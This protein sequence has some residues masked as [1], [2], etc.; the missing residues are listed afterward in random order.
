MRKTIARWWQRLRA[1]GMVLHERQQGQ[2]LI[3]IVFAFIGILAFIGLGVDLANVYTERVKVARAADAAALAAAAELPL[4]DAAKE[5]A[6]AYLQENGYDHT[7]T[8][9]VR[10]LVDGVQVSGPPEADAMTTIW[11]DTAYARKPPSYLEDTPDRIKVRVKREVFMMFMQFVGFTHFPVE[12]TAEAENITS[13]DTVIVYDKSGS[14]EFDTLCYGCWEPVAGQMYPGGDIYPLHWSEITTMTADHCAGWNTETQTYDCGN[15]TSY[16]STYDH[17]NCNYRHHTQTSRYWI[18]I[19]AEE[20]SRLSVDYHRYAYTPGKTYWVVQHNG[21][22]ALYGRP[23][24]VHGAYL[25]HHPYYVFDEGDREVDLG[26]SCVQSAVEDGVC[27]YG[28]PGG[29]F[30]APRADYDFYAPGSGTHTYY[31][32]IRGQGGQT[33]DDDHIFWGVDKPDP[34]GSV[35]VADWFSRDTGINYDGAD[36]GEWE[37]RKLGQASLSQGTHTLNLWAGGAGFDVDRIVISTYDS[38]STPPWDIQDIP[39]NNGRTD[40]ACAPC[41]PRFAGRPGGQTPPA[42]PYRPDCAIDLRSDDIYDDEQPIRAALEAA[43]NFVA[44]LNPRF[45]QI[46]YVRYSGSVEIANEL[47]CLRH[48]GPE[49]VEGNPACNPDWSDPGGEPPRDPDCGCFA[50]VITDTVLYELDVTRAGGSTNIAGGIEQG[51]DVLSTGGSHYGRPGAA[52]VMVL[53]TDGEA[54]VRPNNYCD[55]EDLW[56]EG[57]GAKDCVVYYAQEARDNAIVIYTI[58]LGWSADREL[59]GYVADLTGGEHFFAPSPDK[60][61]PI[62][63]DLFERIFLRLVH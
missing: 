38:G 49:D 15:Y 44:R 50:G 9:T 32:W 51:I 34:P 31:F 22:G 6:L 53:M 45:D 1:G 33:T 5:C 61:D 11:I 41:D 25:T 13:I 62:F 19:E 29:P 55:D 42:G 10:L 60:L 63:D 20:Y 28:V 8:G 23:G 17:N 3:L 14:M 36:S 57:G 27:K 16:D 39:P 37:W 43:K 59:M 40:W 2:T 18:V 47:E 58:S 56:P 12:A 26:V 46:G 24:A 30:K 54:N 48:R 52:H 7:I 4:E 21:H 35:G